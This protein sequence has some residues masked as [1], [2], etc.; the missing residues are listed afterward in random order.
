MIEHAKEEIERASVEAVRSS[1]KM[2]RGRI[3]KQWHAWNARKSHVSKEAPR[4]VWEG[5]ERSGCRHRHRSCGRWYRG[6]W[7]RTCG[8]AEAGSKELYLVNKAKKVQRYAIH[9]N[10]LERV[11]REAIWELLKAAHIEE[12]KKLLSFF[13]EGAS[14]EL[15]DG[16]RYH[17]SAFRHREKTVVSLQRDRH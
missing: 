3:L 15:E 2:K 1:K 9:L 14:R 4:F 7:R 16:K 13:E 5:S 8:A 12:V 17:E 11:L 10:N 6:R